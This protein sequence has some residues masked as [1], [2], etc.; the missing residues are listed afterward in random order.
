MEATVLNVGK[1]VLSGALGYAKSGLAKEVA[2][3]LRIHK[4][5]AFV[6]D[7][8]EMMRSF[9]MEAHEDQEESKVVKTWVNQVRD[10]AY[11]VED[12]L[13]DFAVQTISVANPSHTAR[14]APVAKRMK[15]LR[16]KVED[17]SQRNVLI[18][19]SS[20][21]AKT[22]AIEQ[23]SL[24]AAAIFGID[25]AR[26]AAKQDNQR[27]DLIQLINKEDE[28]LKVIAVWGTSGNIGQTTII[29]AAYENPDVQSKFPSRAWVRV[30]HPFSPKG[31]VQCL[32]N[33]FLAVQGVKGLL[34]TEKTAQDLAQE[35]GGYVNDKRFLVVLTDICT[36]EEWDQIEKCFP[37]NNKGSRIIVSTMQVEVA[38]LCAGKESQASKIKHLSADQTLYAFYDNGSQNGKDS[39]K[40][41]SMLDETTTST[42][43]YIVPHGENIDSQ[44]SYV[45]E[46]KVVTHNRMSV[47]ALEE[48][49]LIGRDKQ[50][51]KIIDLISNNDTQQVQVISVWG[52]GGLGKTTLINSV[53]QSQ[54]LSD[55]FEKCAFVT[56]MRPFNLPEFLRSLAEQLK[57]GSS[58]KKELLENSVSSNKSIALM[59]IDKLTEQLR[60]LLENNTS[61]IILDDLSDI[62]E[63]DLIKPR[64]FP[65]LEKMSRIIVTTR[66]ENVANH[67]SGEVKNVHNLLVLESEDALHL[68][69]LKVSGKDTD[70]LKKNPEL[71]K[72]AERILKKCGG[73]PLAIVV[74][75]G[76]L[77]NRPQTLEEWRQLNDNI[78]AELEMNPE[79]GMIRTVLEKS[80]DG[81]PYHLKSCFLYLSIFS[82][83][84]II[85]RKRLVCRWVAEGYSTKKH[86]K[87]AI[88]IADDY[89]M[90]LKRRSMI[91]PSQQSVRSRKSVDSCKVH[92]LIRDIAI[93]KSAEENLVFRLE[94]G[95]TLNSTSTIRHIAI[96]N[97]WSGDKNE[98]ESIT[99]MSRIRSLLVFG[100]WKPF[101]I[102][103]KMRFLRVLDLEGVRDL[104]YD[105]LDNIWKLIHLKYLSLRGC[106]NI[107]L[108]PD[109][110]GNLMQ[111]QMLDVRDTRVR[112]L[113]KTIS[114]LQHLQY[115]HAGNNTYFVPEPKES[116]MNRCLWG[117]YL[118]A[119][120]CMPL[121]MKI[122]G[123]CHKAVTRRDA[124]TFAC[125][126]EFPDRMMGIGLYEDRG[127]KIPRGVKKLKDLHTLSEVNVG[128]G[129]AVL[130]GIRMLTGLRKLGV[131]GI[132]KKNGPAFHSAICNLRKLESLSVRSVT[133]PPGLRGCLDGIS[134]PPENLQSL[135]L[136]GNL[137][138]LPKWIEELQH[139]VKLKLEDTRLLE[140]YAAMEFLGKL[141]K[142]E[143]LC[144][145]GSS[146]EGEEVDFIKYPQAGRAFG[147]LRVLRLEAMLNIK[148][149]KFEE[150]ALPKLERLLVTGCTTDEIGFPGL[151]FL[152]SLN[153][154]QL[155]VY[156]LWDY[157]RLQAANDSETQCKIIQEETQK[158]TRKK[159]DLKRKIQEQLAG[160]A[161]QPIVTK[162]T[163]PKEVWW[164]SSCNSCHMWLL[165]KP[166]K[167]SRGV[168][169]FE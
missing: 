139:L 8:L 125:C 116:L 112:I 70:L 50:K 128:T 62:S 21:K 161:N 63:W 59:R 146:F 13:Q 10:N 96:S 72:E 6:V 1:S 105:H 66:K 126:V 25:D 45:R 46:N 120:C 94:E 86:G 104:Q 22:E 5:H 133:G 147:G 95:S 64:L 155:N 16:A 12:S 156:F 107:F 43:N 23:L 32:V 58:K 87:S 54:K 102:S 152:P 97:N 154:V 137:E 73:L 100:E 148:T 84:Q 111:L 57:E 168:E 143:I 48:S 121:L 78:S 18:K 65:L 141:P 27:V 127:A 106:Y 83:D 49:R 52:M 162:E 159:G 92:D 149:V 80:Y 85:S 101:F 19:G 41:A 82:E 160:H 3:Q 61:L 34:D 55:N 7:E 157:N 26:R 135:K 31:F 81:L 134:S 123:P 91:L 74:I 169:K 144:L 145:S 153:H 130:R 110:L 142:L 15:D 17:V 9:M 132:N 108:L 131:V 35:F 165:G 67:C 93:A 37:Q 71:A 103:D 40:P 119:T 89:F 79:L 68:F 33:Q 30:M 113:P 140:Q 77:A 60:G 51:V 114:K 163:N 167:E 2:L 39:T 24:N 56:I 38:S 29:R 115:I 76:F 122:D 151:Q 4:D 11:D 118:C 14:A 98:F 129:S 166:T 36:I 136:H 90:E 20:S 42:N 158:A 150:G 47:D 53:Y 44:S 164:T 138:T 99:D 28:D 109:S 88:E 124:W 75:G 117:S 69:S